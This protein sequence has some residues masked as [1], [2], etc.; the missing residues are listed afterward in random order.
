MESFSYSRIS[1]YFTCARCFWYRYIAKIKAQRTIFS[2]DALILG[3]SCHLCAQEG[4][5]KGIE[6]Y[7]KQF[8][9][10][11]HRHV[12]E[13]IKLRYVGAP[14]YEIFGHHQHELKVLGD[15]GY[16]GFIDDY[17]E[18][19]KTLSDFKYSN[20]V[21]RY[22]ESPQI[23]LYKYYGEKQGL[24]IDSLQYVFIPKVAIR[25]KKTETLEQFRARL[26]DEL[27]KKEIQIVPVEYDVKKVEKFL[28]Q[29][30]LVMDIATNH[31][32]EIEFFKCDPKRTFCRNC[33]YRGLCELQGYSDEV[34]D[35]GIDYKQWSDYEKA[36]AQQEEEML[37]GLMGDDE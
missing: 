35:E 22:L 10:L 23:H 1:Q 28:A 20:A 16:I 2:N 12:N 37:E 8:D 33:D 36:L 4:L 19:T 6:Y 31:S 25:Q 27:M 18:E 7:E 3:Q 26:M 24:D 9:H 21:D 11:N 13:E 14:L 34:F 32:E 30:D 5:E 15:D 29:K 17:D